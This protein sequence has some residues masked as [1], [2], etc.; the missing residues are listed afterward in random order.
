MDFVTIELNL[1]RRCIIQH[2][3]FCYLIELFTKLEYAD[4]VWK[5]FYHLLTLIN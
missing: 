2:E 5:R 3:A 4:K 1:S